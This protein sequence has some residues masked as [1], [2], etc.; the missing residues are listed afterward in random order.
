MIAAAAMA[1]DAFDGD[2]Q[3][4]IAVGNHG[5]ELVD[6]RGRFGRRFD[7]D[8]AP[9]AVEDGFGIKGIGGGVSMVLSRHCHSG[10]GLHAKSLRLPEVQSAHLMVCT[11]S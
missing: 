2:G 11:S 8:P 10:T 5:R 1:R 4:A 9:D 3:I 6:L 7:F